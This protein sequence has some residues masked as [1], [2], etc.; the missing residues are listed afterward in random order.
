MRSW[1][2]QLGGLWKGAWP[3]THAK[4][5]DLVFA[6]AP[7]RRRIL[8]QSRTVL[9]CAGKMWLDRGCRTMA[10]K[11]P[12]VTTKMVQHGATALMAERLRQ[13]SSVRQAFN[14]SGYF[15]DTLLVRRWMVSRSSLSKVSAC[16]RQ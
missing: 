4:F 10:H 13:V 5:H 15:A 7:Q 9:D 11:N 12:I 2:W 6:T 1:E 16:I 3:P 8:V 14:K